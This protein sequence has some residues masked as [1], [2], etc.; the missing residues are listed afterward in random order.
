MGVLTSLLTIDIV[1]KEEVDNPAF[2][3]NFLSLRK[4]LREKFV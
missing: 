2:Y 3:L 1:T 4:D